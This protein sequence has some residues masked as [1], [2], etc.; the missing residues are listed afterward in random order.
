MAISVRGRSGGERPS[1][2]ENLKTRLRAAELAMTRAAQ[3]M[4]N[5]DGRIEEYLNLMASMRI[6]YE[7]AL[8]RGVNLPGG[9]FKAGQ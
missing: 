6:L 5:R 1:A 8:R 2:F 9:T 7:H 3:K 4:L